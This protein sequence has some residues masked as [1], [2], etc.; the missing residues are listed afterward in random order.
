MASM[1]VAVG[2]IGLGFARRL[3]KKRFLADAGQA[4]RCLGFR[5]G[6]KE[7][8]ARHKNKSIA[9]G[10]GVK[11][12]I[13][14]GLDAQKRRR[15]RSHL[16]HWDDVLCWGFNQ[17]YPASWGEASGMPGCPTQAGTHTLTH[18]YR[19]GRSSNIF[20]SSGHM[21]RWVPR[22]DQLEDVRPRV[23]PDMEA[24]RPFTFGIWH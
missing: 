6:G 21:C 11:C 17:Q 2:V 4:A 8:W 3:Q 5:V 15:R 12:C 16:R 20:D 18:T 23:V 7:K 1:R 24:R 19:C 14:F 13:E 10:V 9:T 22:R